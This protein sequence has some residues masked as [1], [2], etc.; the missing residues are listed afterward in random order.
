MALSDAFRFFPALS[1]QT[2]RRRSSYSAFLAISARVRLCGPPGRKLPQQHRHRHRKADQRRGAAR[3]DHQNRR[4]A[5]PEPLPVRHAREAVAGQRDRQHDDADGAADRRLEELGPGE[6]LGHEQHRGRIDEHERH[7]R[8]GEPEPERGVAGLERIGAGHAGAGVG[9]E[10]DRRRD[11]GEHAVIEDEE[12]RD[13]LRHA[14]H[15]E[16][17]RRD[18][19]HD[20]IVRGGRYAAA[21]RD[22]DDRRHHQREEQRHRLGVEQARRHEG[23]EQRG[24]IRRPRR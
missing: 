19:H 8:L 18:R 5:E 6:S 17:G 23:A 14:E 11:V 21:E 3:R 20:E 13:E 16:R 24:N 1:E 22:A 4:G 9:G 12:V 15:G 2:S 10:R 7:Q